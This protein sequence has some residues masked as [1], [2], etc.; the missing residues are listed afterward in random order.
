[1]NEEI[2]NTIK[3]SG[4]FYD[5]SYNSFSMH[6][7]Y[8]KISLNGSSKKGIAHKVLPDFYELPIS[9]LNLKGKVVPFG[10]GAYFRLYPFSLFNFGINLILKSHGAYMF[11]L[12]PWEL[13]PNQPKVNQASFSF[14]FRH[15]INL[16]KT[17][18]RLQSLIKDFSTCHFV[19][20]SQYIEQINK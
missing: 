2:L 7:R 9:N 4:Y 16:S 15:Y 14:K 8:G 1:M 18:K 12:H 11:Y 10:G 17:Y 6:D 5:S 19:T 3:E 13:D 20:C